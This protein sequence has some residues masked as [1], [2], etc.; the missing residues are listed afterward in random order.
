MGYILAWLMPS[1]TSAGFA[2]PRDKGR[3]SSNRGFLGE[4]WNPASPQRVLEV[5]CG[6]GIFLEWFR[7]QGHMVTGLEPSDACLE[8]ARG[9]LGHKVRLTRGFAENLPYEDNEFDTVALITTLE[10]VDD[11]FVAL[12]EAFRVARRNVLLGALNRYSMGGLH[13][14]V[15]SFWKDSLYSRARFLAFSSLAGC[16][17][18]FFAGPFRSNGE[19]VFPFRCH[20][21]PTSGLSSEFLCRSTTPSDFSSLCGLTCIAAFAHYRLLSSMKSRRGSKSRPIPW[22]AG[23]LA[24]PPLKIR[25]IREQRSRSI[26]AFALFP[27]WRVASRFQ[28]QPPAFALFE[29]SS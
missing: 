21:F 7:S 6:T 1:A 22:D 9:R 19:H 8:L 25:W 29:R 10:F 17:A 11:P 23:G 14:G 2:P 27:V 18:E 3:W 15:K 5:G 26:E 4:V 16:A 24:R 12:K 20:Y 28:A 13:Y